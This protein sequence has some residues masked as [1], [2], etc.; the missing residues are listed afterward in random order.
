M[1]KSGYYLSTYLHFDELSCAFNYE[2]RHDQNI[3]LWRLYKNNLEL[4]HYWELER[5]TGIKQHATSFCDIYE[6]RAIINELLSKYDLTLN[7]M[8]DVWGTPGLSASFDDDNSYNNFYDFTYHSICH[9]FSSILIDTEMFYN[10]NIIALALDGGPD[11]VVDYNRNCKYKYAGIV[12]CKGKIKVFPVYSPGEFWFEAFE[13]FGYREGTLM[14]LSNACTCKLKDEIYTN[15]YSMFSNNNDGYYL[16]IKQFLSKLMLYI[17]EINENDAHNL[18]E[19]FDL[20]FSLNDNKISA[21]IKILQKLS[22]E[23]V[24]YNI[25][26]IKTDYCIK[27]EDTYLSLSGGYALNC[28]T[29]SYI[30]Q[31]YSFKGFIAPP[32]VGDCGKSLGIGLYAFF[33]KMDKINFKLKNAYYGDEDIDLYETIEKYR[34]NDYI[35]NISQIDVSQVVEDI[36]HSVI[37]W[38]R[39]EIGPRAL[40]HRSLLADPRSIEA[41]NSLNQIKQRQWWRPVAPIILEDD[42]DD[43][44]ENPYPSPYML[45]TF[46]FKSNLSELVPAVSHLDNTARVQ[47][48]NNKD[49]DLL[50]DVILAFKENTGIPI[51]CN[52]SLNDKGEPIIN[53]IRRAID[54]SLNKKIEVIYINGNRIHLC[55]HDKY[56][57]QAS[58]NTI[59]LKT[60]SLIEKKK[61]MKK[62]NPYGITKRDLRLYQ[63]IPTLLEKYD[64][65][66]KSGV[67]DYLKDIENIRKDFYISD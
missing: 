13:F 64:L 20:H 46:K 65:T 61:I 48:I 57:P 15:L 59:Q 23:I 5:L 31:K 6:T 22:I 38:F 52:T 10:N 17:N 16:R 12:S 66:Q 62:Y 58:F 24:E 11:R 67:D 1:L 2:H 43:W 9:L 49:Y 60:F 32:C 50:Y 28:P 53:T 54:F 35:K 40:G 8:L 39:A 41:K 45:H 26:K 27:T 21:Y 4:I 36:K 14:A 47:S 44:F 18:L 56:T 25:E 3:A 51:L 42:L 29:N 30:M 55:N 7:D 37:V 63:R 33:N 34:F 19:D